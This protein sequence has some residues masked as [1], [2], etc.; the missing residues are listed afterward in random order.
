MLVLVKNDF[1]L[2]KAKVIRMFLSTGNKLEDLEQN[3]GKG[4]YRKAEL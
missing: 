2:E 1:Y 3:K 4:Q